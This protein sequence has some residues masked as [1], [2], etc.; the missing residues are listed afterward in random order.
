MNAEKNTRQ[1]IT[2]IQTTTGDASN[3][4]NENNSDDENNNNSSAALTNRN[5]RLKSNSE[6]SATTTASENKIKQSSSINSTLVTIPSSR[7]SSLPDQS[8]I[9]DKY[10]IYAPK[11]LPSEL[12]SSDTSKLSLPSAQP[13]KSLKYGPIKV[14]GYSS[15]ITRFD[16]QPDLCKD[17]N[18]SGYCGY[19]DSC[20][21]L[22]DRT[23]Y[24]SSIT[25]EKEFQEKINKEKLLNNKNINHNN[26]NNSNNNINNSRCF[27]CKQNFINPI[28]TLCQHYFCENCALNR[29]SK[30]NNSK[31]AICNKDTEGSFSV[32]KEL[33]NQIKQNESNNENDESDK[34]DIEE[35]EKT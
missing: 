10:T 9:R 24:K 11:N 18:E 27:I 7:S 19:G 31:C 34:S 3:N 1:T 29:F 33:I 14:S 28:Q 6:L 26:T 21:F 20:K 5:K 4:S 22:H 2:A 8:T 13:K 23:E 25:L 30:E 15:N 12:S 17:Y 32:A 35:N 16:Y